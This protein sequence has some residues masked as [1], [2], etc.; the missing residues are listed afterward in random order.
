MSNSWLDY[1]TTSNLFKQSYI[2]DFIDVSG[3]LYVRNHNINGISSDI[4]MNGTV[5]CNS[6]TITGAVTGINTDVQTELDTKQNILTTGTGISI[7]AYNTISSSGGGGGTAP[8]DISSNTTTSASPWVQVGGTITQKQT[9]VSPATVHSQNG[10]FRSAVISGDGSTILLGSPLVDPFSTTNTNSGALYVYSLHPVYG[11]IT[12]GGSL[13]DSSYP[14]VGI[15][16]DQLGMYQFQLAINSDG[17]IIAFGPNKENPNGTWGYIK[18]FSVSGSTTGGSTI[19]QRGT[20]KTGYYSGSWSNN[21]SYMWLGKI[22]KMALNG[23]RIIATAPKINPWPYGSTNKAKIRIYDWDGTD[24]QLHSM[25]SI[26]GEGADPGQISVNDAGTRIAVGMSVFRQSGGPDTT[27]AARVYEWNEG[28]STWDPM[29]ADII[30][31]QVYNARSFGGVSLSGNGNILITNE[32]PNASSGHTNYIYIYDGTNWVKRGDNIGGLGTRDSLN[33]DGTVVGVYSGSPPNRRIYAYK[34]DGS[35][36]NQMG[37]GAA[38]GTTYYNVDITDDGS[39]VVGCDNSPAPDTAHVSKVTTTIT[40]DINV[41]SDAIVTQNVDVSG[42]DIIVS[43]STVHSSDVR[44]KSELTAVTSALE[45]ILKL[46]PKK[47]NKESQGGTSII[48]TGFIAQKIWYKIPELRHLIQFP[49]GIYPSNIKDISDNILEPEPKT[50]DI[51]ANEYIDY[52]LMQII[53]VVD[54]EQTT[55]DIPDIQISKPN[56]EEY[57]WGTKPVGINYEGLIAY[58]VGAIQELKTKIETQTTEINNLTE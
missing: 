23:D 6:I 52:D 40:S 19:T 13:R 38:F 48:D 25:I 17:S 10:W 57:G 4:S 9:G 18:V 41:T 22:V 51:S 35:S 20:T 44:L 2:K 7:D 45:M 50:I 56:Y 14:L 42:G 21:D 26:E 39:T 32:R 47:Y 5:T 31:A 11:W 33:Y 53:G 54:G 34:Y 36:W 27:G 58:L 28:T 43:G 24:Y 55:R 8:T 3:H 15:D 1:P 49:E 37:G 16:G 12:L 30:G 29:G 46:E